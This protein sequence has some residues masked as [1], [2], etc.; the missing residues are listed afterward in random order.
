MNRL[1]LDFLEAVLQFPVGLKYLSLLQTFLTGFATSK[2][3]IQCVRGPY[4]G[5][6]MVRGPTGGAYHWPSVKGKKEA[7]NLR[8]AVYHHGVQ[9]IIILYI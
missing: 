6:E 5:A 1:T 3:L 7:A 8:F 9:M 2:L 4:N